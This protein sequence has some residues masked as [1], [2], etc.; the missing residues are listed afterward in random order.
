MA[1]QI[2]EITIGTRITNFGAH[3]ITV[4]GMASGGMGLVVWGPNRGRDD[5]MLAVKLPRP[6]RLAAASRAQ[7]AAILADFEREA[8]TWCHLWI[9]PNIVAADGLLRLS[10]LGDLPAI[11]L[12]YAPE[13]SLRDL[14]QAVHHPDSTQALGLEGVFAWGQ[15]VA[16]ALATIHRPDPTLE[17][18]D[19]LVHCDLKPENVLLNTQGWAML[20]DLGL[21]RALASLADTAPQALAVST[22]ALDSSNDVSG[23][24]DASRVSGLSAEQQAQV[25]QMRRLLAQAG[26]A[27]PSPA[28]RVLPDVTQEQALYATRTICVSPAQQATLNAALAAAGGRLA[29]SSRPSPPVQPVLPALSPS[30]T[31]VIAQMGSRGPVAGTPPYM[32]PEQWLGLDAVEPASDV[33]ALGVLLFELFAGVGGRAGYPHTPDPLLLLTG[34]VFAAW[35][36]AHANGPSRRLSNLEVRALSDGPL[37][38]LRQDGRQ[39]DAEEVLAGL[40]TLI[41]DCLAFSPA[42]RPT[43]R[44]VQ[45]RLAGLAAQAGLNTLT[46]PEYS[47]TAERESIFWSNLGTT[48]GE[49]GQYEEKLR[50]L[51]KAVDLAPDNPQ[52]RE[53]LGNALKQL[54]RTEQEAAEQGDHAAVQQLRAQVQAYLEEAVRTFQTAEADLTPEQLVLYPH[55]ANSL[56]YNLGGAFADLGRYAE[57]ITATQRALVADTNDAMSYRQLAVIYLRWSREAGIPTT[58]QVER[59]EQGLANMRQALEIAPYFGGGQGL[60]AAIQRGL[61]EARSR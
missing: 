26:V 50:L 40:E 55:L 2:P 43:A 41:S 58:I 10:A 34:G 33:Y 29:Q 54:A 36:A 20:T 30:A 45:E 39:A 6:D 18:P 11:F 60:L 48:Y 28:P 47:R 23:T 57:A 32:P 53:T 14:L 25:A 37:L 3:D 49:M 38:K 46:I 21:T 8:L 42:A 17:R 7:R 24:V 16:A 12:R 4:S 44:Q 31:E 13:G 9:H 59:L 19:P 1:D 51:R 52:R 5:K 35:C 27:L 15:M 22:F 61:D 56:P